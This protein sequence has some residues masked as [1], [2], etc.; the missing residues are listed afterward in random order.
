MENTGFQ[1]INQIAL[2]IKVLIIKYSKLGMHQSNYKNQE[3]FQKAMNAKL[4][5]LILEHQD[6]IW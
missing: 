5:A 2:H 3:S 6:V 1:I 4:N